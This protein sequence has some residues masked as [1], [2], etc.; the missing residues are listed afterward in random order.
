M[1][2]I[3]VLIFVLFSLSQAS[4]TIYVKYRGEVQVN[5]NHL[6]QID[7]KP[8]SL[9]KDMY[10]YDEAKYLVVKLKSTYYHYCG[11]DSMAVN[12]WINSSSIGQH[13]LNNIKGNYDC[14]IHPIPEY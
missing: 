5:N 2:K 10:Y 1:K 11:I 13:Y 3:L 8:S 9:V 4:K 6:V 7:L 12:R 14:R